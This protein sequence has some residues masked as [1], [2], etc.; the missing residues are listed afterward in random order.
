V[1][2]TD[3]EALY[4]IGFAFDEMRLVLE[5]GGAVGLAAL[6][7]GRVETA[8]DGCRG[9]IGRQCRRRDFS[10]GGQRLSFGS[11]VTG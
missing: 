4:A 1:A 8:A 10:R 7:A 3:P 11:R 5:P 9:A 2:A 6:L